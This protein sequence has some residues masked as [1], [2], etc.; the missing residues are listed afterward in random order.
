MPG[1]YSVRV[2]I[3]GLKAPLTGRLAVEGDP[4][5]KFAAAD[6]AARQAILMQVYD[7]TRTLGEARAAVRALVTQRD[8]IKSNL[9]DARGDSLNARVT[10]LSGDVDRA[11]NAI[12][13]QRSPIES[14]SG[15][16]SVDQRKSLE[17]ALDDARKATADLN[18]LVSTDIPAAYR[19]AGKAWSRPVSTVQQPDPRASGGTR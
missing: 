3:T 6:R 17:F 4:L 9:G 16:P 10:R 2:A 18:R 12:N 13:G 1:T 5:P 7:W 8:T 19:T 14:W 15:L 11:F